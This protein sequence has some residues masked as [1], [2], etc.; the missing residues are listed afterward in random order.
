MY[1]MKFDEWGLRKYKLNNRLQSSTIRPR[2]C[3]RLPRLATSPSSSESCPPSTAGLAPE[4][5]LKFGPNITIPAR[6]LELSDLLPFIQGEFADEYALEVLI[7]KWQKGGEYMECARSF[8]RDP[9]RYLGSRGI[10]YIPRT[11]RAL[12]SLIY[13]CVPPAE[14]FPLTKALLE[15]DLALEYET[16]PSNPHNDS[17][18]QSW[19]SAAVAPTWD[20]AK[21]TL[22]TM[23]SAQFP[24][25]GQA[26]MFLDSALVVIAERILKRYMDK[27]EEFR[28]RAEPLGRSD[29]NAEYCRRYLAI[30]KDFNRT[31]KDLSPSWYKYS[32]QIIGWDSEIANKVQESQCKCAEFSAENYQKYRKLI[33]LYTG[34]EEG[35]I[36]WSLND[37]VTTATLYS[38]VGQGLESHFSI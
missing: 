33:S 19:R 34:I 12:F 26:Q 36:D 23:F 16:H 38:T 13:D 35:F 15:A 20:N 4:V 32:L 22:Y 3:P 37:L 29:T 28:A 9:V 8:L 27:L 1:R 18:I 11:G 5:Q 7:T 14:Q 10:D 25:K 31:D 21:R 6:P 2:K 24:G 17:W 30:L